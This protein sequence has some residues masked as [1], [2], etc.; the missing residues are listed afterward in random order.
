MRRPA[1]Y[2]ACLLSVTLVAGSAGCARDDGPVIEKPQAHAEESSQT[3]TPLER[4]KLRRAVLD[5]V[6]AFVAAWKASD[7][8]A[9]EAALPADVASQFTSVWSEYA[10]EGLAVRHVHTLKNLDVTELNADATQATVSYAYT[11]RSYLVD[12]SGKK[13]RALEPFE[14]SL[15]LT[16]ERDPAASEWRIVRLFMK[17]AG[18]R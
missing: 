3:I 18:Y 13:V 4:G 17:E 14:S 6:R 8:D 15:T 9:L 7:R 1:A 10:D 12:S 11:D 2:A 5:E 16:V